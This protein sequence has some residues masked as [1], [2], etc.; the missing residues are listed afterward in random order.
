MPT[1]D[2]S[3]FITAESSFNA[4]DVEWLKQNS[5]VKLVEKNVDREPYDF[6]VTVYPNS[7]MQPFCDWNQDNYGPIHIP[8]KGEQIQLTPEN[9]EVYRRVIDVYE[10]NEWLEKDGKVYING[11]EVTSYTFKQDYYWMMGDNR[12]QSADSRFW[13]FV[14]EDHVV[15]KPVFTWFS[16]ENQEYQEGGEIR[17]KRMFRLVD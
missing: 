3:N 4:E 1:T 14:P 2:S 11:A 12:H 9:I 16:K 5:K 6:K 13:G 15:G 17:W 10:N 8:A 7:T